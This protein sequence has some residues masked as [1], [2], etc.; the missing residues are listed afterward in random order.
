MKK[1]RTAVIGQSE[2]TRSTNSAQT[3]TSNVVEETKLEYAH[4][5]PSVVD[6]GAVS[7]N[8]AQYNP[9][10]KDNRLNASQH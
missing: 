8:A 1:S 7:C 4:R 9:Q 2:K 6:F 5:C 10:M 3:S